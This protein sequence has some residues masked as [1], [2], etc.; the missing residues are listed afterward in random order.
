[1]FSFSAHTPSVI[2]THPPQINIIMYEILTFYPQELPQI[3]FTLEN[4]KGMREE[5][6][7]T[8][9]LYIEFFIFT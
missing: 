3:N 2:Q 4:Y 5:Q 8:L 7:A 1:M 6:N 9:D